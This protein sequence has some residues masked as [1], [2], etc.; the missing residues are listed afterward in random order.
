MRL[1]GLLEGARCQVQI[2]IGYGDA[3][4]P[5]VEE[6]DY[7]LI[8]EDLATPRLRVYPRY[9]VVAEKFEAVVSLGMANSRMKDFF[10]LWVLSQHCEFDATILADAIEAT[11]ERRRTEIPK[12]AALGLT[13]TFASDPK[14]QTQWAAF[15]RKN[16]L[17]A[18]A[19]QELI[20]VIAG[21]LLPVTA[22]V[23]KREQETGRW[24]NRGPWVYS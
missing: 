15:L 11:F 21:S 12:G 20:P 19:L 23:R 14:N 7:P 3:V 9:S 10:D 2:D 8:L 17:D 1:H 5:G 22:L 6:A 16:N 18:P 24:P 4:T 13:D